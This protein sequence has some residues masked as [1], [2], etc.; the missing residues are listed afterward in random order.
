[1]DTH[2]NVDAGHDTN[3]KKPATE[4]EILNFHPDEAP[5]AVKVIEEESRMVVRAGSCSTGIQFRG[6]KEKKVL[7]GDE[8]TKK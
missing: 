7:G 3:W 8:F 2:H 6:R 5:G 1:M 4:G